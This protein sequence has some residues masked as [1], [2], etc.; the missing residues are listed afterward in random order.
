MIKAALF[1]RTTIIITTI[2]LVAEP[3]K[4][5][6]EGTLHL[7]TGGAQAS[8]VAMTMDEVKS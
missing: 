7:T 8:T 6:E 2:M 3:G 5:V 1:I 4:E